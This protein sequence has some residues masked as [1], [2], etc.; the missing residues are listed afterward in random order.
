MTGVAVQ[1]PVSL[2]ARRPEGPL[3]A[4]LFWS[5]VVHAVL[6][7]ISLQVVRELC[8]DLAVGFEERPLLQRVENKTAYFKDG[9]TKSVDAII[10]CTGYKH[11][12]PFLA[13]E[14]RLKTENRMWPLGL[15]KGVA[16]VRGVCPNNLEYVSAAGLPSRVRSQNPRE[17]V[18]R[19]LVPTGFQPCP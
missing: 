9:S 16:Q 15:Y 1:A 3:L 11:H 18:T 12:F 7:G 14:L 6:G 17:R 13:D 19:K 10:L 8:A 4:F 2:L 5:A